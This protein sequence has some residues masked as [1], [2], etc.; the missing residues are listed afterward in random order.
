MRF[1]GWEAIRHDR[2]G[3]FSRDSDSSLMFL[4]PVCVFGFLL[5]PYLDATF[6]RA[7]HNLTPRESK[8]AFGPGFGVVFFSMI[9]L[10]LGYSAAIEHSIRLHGNGPPPVVI[11]L[12]VHFVVQAFF[13][14]FVH[15]RAMPGGGLRG[16]SRFGFPVLGVMAIVVGFGVG[17]ADA[18]T[19]N[20][21]AGIALGEVIY[22][23]FMAFYGL[24]F[25]AYVWLCML[26][27]RDGHSGTLGERG[28]RK[29]VVLALA[30]ALA[31]PCYWM[32]FIERQTWWLAPGLGIVLLARLLVLGQRKSDEVEREARQSRAA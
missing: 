31:T 10:T 14:V 30:V 9:L 2:A 7:R 22:R 32:G 27:T 18:E 12:F 17:L 11:M 20:G 25:P 6:L 8:A 1:G 15:I 5:C 29:L 16:F 19:Q 13:T 4:A 26:P 21:Y 3:L 24:V 28:R 23:G